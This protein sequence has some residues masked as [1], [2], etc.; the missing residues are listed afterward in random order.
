MGL[1]PL[2]S[3][4]V[5]VTFYKARLYQSYRLPLVKKN[6]MPFSPSHW[7]AILDYRG[8]FVKLHATCH[9]QFC[10]HPHIDSATF[11]SFPCVELRR[12]GHIGVACTKW[13]QN[14]L[15]ALLDLSPPIGI[16]LTLTFCCYFRKKHLSDHTGV[17]LK[18]ISIQYP[19][20]W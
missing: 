9:V 11:Q 14:G 19:F 12:S 17:T 4:S 10:E 3:I 8:N 7:A 18:I 15:V 13:P 1:E 6:V 16:C 5:K 2:T 20:I